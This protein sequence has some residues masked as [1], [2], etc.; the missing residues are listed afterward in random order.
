MVD[1]PHHR[2]QPAQAVK[3]DPALARV[4]RLAQRRVSRKSTFSRLPA[5]TRHPTP[6]RRPTLGRHLA[7]H[8]ATMPAPNERISSGNRTATM[9]PA[10]LRSARRRAPFPTSLH[11]AYLATPPDSPAPRPRPSLAE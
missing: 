2:R 11:T 5:L 4:D 8:A 3:A 9:W 10:L 6:G 1:A 7:A